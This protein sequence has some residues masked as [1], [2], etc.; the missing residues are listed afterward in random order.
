MYLVGNAAYQLSDVM[1]VP[2][3]G[4]QH[5]DDSGKDSFNF[6]LSQVCIRIKMAAFGLLQT[7]WGVLNKP[8]LSLRILRS[9]LVTV[10]DNLRLML[11]DGSGMLP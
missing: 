11:P 9:L 2:F 5:C 10:L 3:T 1:L 8:W 7:K 6:F 4:S